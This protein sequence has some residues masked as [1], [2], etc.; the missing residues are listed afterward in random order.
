MCERM[1]YYALGGGLGHLTRTIALARQL[2]RRLPGTHRVLAN[3]EFRLAAQALIEVE[4]RS[5]PTHSQLELTLVPADLDL[6]SARQWIVGWLDELA[7]KQLVVDTFPRGLGGELS[8]WLARP[9]C[10]APPSHRLLV[11]RPLPPEYVSAFDVRSFVSKHYARIVVPGES[12]L[13]AQLVETLETPAFLLRDH[14]ELP[15]AAEAAARLE[16]LPEQGAVLVVA[17]GRGPEVDRWTNW[18]AR[19]AAKWPNDLPPLRLIRPRDACG[20]ESSLSPVPL[21]DCLPAVRL[22]LGA[23]GYN[24]SHETATLGIPALQYAESRQYDRQAA[25]V[26]RPL[27]LDDLDQVVA[28]VRDSILPGAPHIPAY[29][30]GASLA[31]QWWA[32]QS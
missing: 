6:E 19:L 1:A 31:A 20:T 5:L 21:I 15:T 11:S 13:L 12:S 27:P 10:S 2:A 3:T 22:V 32:E 8:D 25:R 24:L 16:V 7:P 26:R 30:N 14:G 18:T 23:A 28:A 9:D 4:Q 17:S 29:V